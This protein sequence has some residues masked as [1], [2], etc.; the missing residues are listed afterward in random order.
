MKKAKVTLLSFN[1]SNHFSLANGYLKAYAEQDEVIGKNADI[2]IVDFDAEHHN[3]RQALCYLTGEQPDIVGFSC[4]C[5]NMDK[6]LELSRLLKQLHPKTQI[7]LGGP[8]VGPIARKCMMENPAVDVV[9]MGEGELTFQELLRSYLDQSK[10]MAS[11]TGITYRQDGKILS[12]GQRPLIDDLADLPSPYLTGVLTPRDGVTYIETYRGCPYRC[13]FCFEGKNFPK[14]RFFPDE[15][16]RK[17]I[18]LITA[19]PSIQSFHVVDSVFN[20]KKNRFRRI[21]QMFHDANRSGAGL[22]TVEVMAELVDEETVKLLKQAN[23]RSVETGPQTVNMNTIKNI[24]RYYQKEKFNRGIKLLLD[25]DI[26]VLTDL[27]IGLPGDNFFR[28]LRSAKAMIQLKPT[29]I[30][31]SILH[32]L[33]GTE[34]Y[35]NADKFGL[36]FDDQ[37]PHLV[38]KN[39]TFPYEE[40]DKAVVFAVSMGKEYNLKFP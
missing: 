4:Y 15:R 2:Q 31:F 18:E 38:L 25:G 26:D 17:E 27:I 23:V 32:V 16:I 5:W 12:T 8:E 19:N 30:V 1:W 22:T 24:S 10:S 37:A 29:T 35:A 14:L 3:V 34:L 39:D 20:L 11:I 33:P 7:V 28:F 40:I 36:L 6:I 9:V 21:A 13:A